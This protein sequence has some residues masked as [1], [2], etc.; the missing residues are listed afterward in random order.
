MDIT[1]ARTIIAASFRRSRPSRVVPLCEEIETLDRSG[2]TARADEA[3]R[4]LD[5][6]AGHYTD[7][8]FVGGRQIAKA[9][10]MTQANPQH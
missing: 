1:T 10:R 8:R 3:V 6:L 2:D 7:G 5:D 4:T 9:L